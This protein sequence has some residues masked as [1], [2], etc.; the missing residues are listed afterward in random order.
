MP[1]RTAAPIG[2]IGNYWAARHRATPEEVALLQVLADS[3]SIA[4][5]NIRRY[6]V[7]EQKTAAAEEANEMKSQFL[8]TVSHE[9]RTPLNAII[10]YTD[11]LIDGIYGRMT[12]EAQMPLKGV[13][14]NAADLLRLIDNILNLARLESG[15]REVQTET[16]DLVPLLRE[17]I[18]DL[19]PLIEQKAIFLRLNVSSALLTL[20]S[21]EG[22]IR[23][24]FINLLA[25]AIK[26]TKNGEISVT[27]R[28]VP[29]KGGAEI[30]IRD[31]GIGISE[32]ALRKIFEPFYQTNGS[33]T[34]EFGGVGLGLTI[35][36]QLLTLLRGSI[37][38]ESEVG[39]GST[40]TVFLP[41]R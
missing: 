10:G 35:V 14:R 33:N 36:K 34:R 11:L 2:A 27:A 29:E 20:E 1:I 40:L 32:A 6:E 5:E 28:A 18:T 17:L 19:R 25:N 39:K 22:K 13:Q 31:T 9:L 41:C 38:A 8:S 7:L 23:Q 30:S 4:M 21:D 37:R 24:I 12:E 16:V 15:N 26:F 3:A